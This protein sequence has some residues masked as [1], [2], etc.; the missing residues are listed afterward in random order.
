[1]LEVKNLHV[2]LEDTP[3]LRGINL[4]VNLGEVHVIL[5]PNGSGKS[6]LGRVLLGDEKY[7][8][9]EGSITFFDRDFDEMEAAERA[10]AG[11]FLS[12]QAPPEL[13]GV[14]AREFLFAAKK[15]TDPDFASSFKL[16]QELKEHLEKVHLG[17]EFLERE[18]NKGASGGERRKMEL[19]SMLTLKPKL[20]FLD[21]I[22]SGV[23]VDARRA[24]GATL[25][26]FMGNMQQSLILVTHTDKF[27][28]EVP[29][30]HVHI[31]VKGKI[32]K[33]GGPSLVDYVH[34]HGFAEFLPK[35]KGLNVIQ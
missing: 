2:Q 26:S 14:S 32:V 1:M 4:Q 18:L 27:L 16:K 9:T 21:E 29:P 5:G 12:F 35:K 20:A 28:Q 17:D 30:T 6:T 19:V 3:I 15:A 11:F 22:D 7:E 10:Q 8:K 31:L 25:R 24:M 33:T 34:E 13:D 23:D